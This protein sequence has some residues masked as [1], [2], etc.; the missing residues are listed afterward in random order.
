MGAESETAI[1]VPPDDIDYDDQFAM[2]NGKEVLDTPNTVEE[3]RRFRSKSR[4][5]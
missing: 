3:K 1:I 5:F 4:T 2:G